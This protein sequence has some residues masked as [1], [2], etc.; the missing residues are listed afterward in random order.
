[1]GTINQN[2]DFLFV[3]AGAS[4]TLLLMSMEKHELLKDKNVL[5]IDPD[6]KNNNDKTYCFWSKNSELI[7]FRCKHLISHHWDEISVNRNP[8][9]ILHPNHYFHIPG[10]NLYNE[11]KRLISQYN[12]QRINSHVVDITSVNDI[13]LVKTENEIWESSMVFDSRPP[14]YLP[15]QS[16]DAHLLQ[17]FIG[18]V[19]KT[20][21]RISENNCLDLMDF[22]VEQQS[23]TQF[24]YVLPLE[25]GKTL[26]ELTRFGL[27]M[28]SQN[29]ADPILHEYIKNRFGEYEIL[30]KEIGCIPMS[31]AGI[32]YE[33]I[34]RVIPIGSRAGAVKPSTG[35][36]FKNMFNHAEKIAVSLKNNEQPE[37][38][39]TSSRFRF[40]DRLLL[41]ILSRK[42]F[43]GKL[44]FQSLFKKNKIKNVLDFLDERTSLFQ[45]F[46]IF[47]K[48]PIITFLNAVGWVFLSRIQQIKTTLGLLL[49]TLFLLIIYTI[50]PDIFNWVQLLIFISGMFLIGIPHGAV[51][52]LL[53]TQNFNIKI[54]KSF[55]LKYLGLVFLNLTLWLIFPIL[56][57]PFF[58]GYSAW[59]FGQTDFLEWQPK[60][61]N[62]YKNFIWGSIILGI[63]LCG[64]ALET[65][66]ILEN[67]NAWKI[68]LNKN[69]GYNVSIILSVTAIAWAI[70]E[71]RLK[72]FLCALIIAMSIY[73]P[74]ITSFGIYFIGQHSMSGWSH[75]KNGLNL[76]NISLF[77][78]ALPFTAGAFLLLIAFLFLLK[79]DYLSPLNEH[80]ITIFFVFISCISF[81]HVMAMSRFYNKK[82]KI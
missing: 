7:S 18:Y 48:L 38:I 58:I 73:L 67:M 66:T 49:S 70:T 9:E 16:D 64:H 37:R 14:K 77:K 46:K 59:H 69:E 44:I 80:L 45:D 75:L 71:R 76:N 19:I 51:D 21:E 29:E 43:M 3:G 41:L 31:T 36:A 12:F 10:I 60:K 24:V 4:S 79:Y 78:K 35:Y 28:I 26:V 81:P 22:K 42:P 1:M 47:M 68:T 54:Q 23:S 61:I 32:N 50:A 30:S 25:D 8:K 56:A 63:I 74:L 39:K 2:I 72:M 20:E 5:I 15:L 82:N 6:T 62:G 55:I 27:D 65:N 13:V 11:L 17:S 52:H 40:Y 33:N 34:P 53:E 57:L